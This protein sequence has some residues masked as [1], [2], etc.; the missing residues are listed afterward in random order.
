MEMKAYEGGNAAVE[1]DYFVAANV[2]VP[3]LIKMF[4]GERPPT[5]P[6]INPLHCQPSELADLSPQLI[7]VGGGEFAIY[8]SKKWAEMCR[9]AGLECSL[10]IEWGQLHIYAMG[11]DWIAPSIRRKTDDRIIE[12]VQSHIGQNT[13]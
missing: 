11:S 1:T 4:I 8:D 10:T 9:S 2:A 3:S 12:W 13:V 6:E 5:A 7:L